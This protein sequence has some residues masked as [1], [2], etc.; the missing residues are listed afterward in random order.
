MLMGDANGT[1]HLPLAS[2]RGATGAS[3]SNFKINVK[4]SVS[5]HVSNVIKVISTTGRTAKIKI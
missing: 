4:T 2:R 1:V 5:F 3:A